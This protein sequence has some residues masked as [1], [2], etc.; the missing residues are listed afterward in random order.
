MSDAGGGNGG[1][2]GGGGS[3]CGGRVKRMKQ[4]RVLWTEVGGG[5]ALMDAAAACPVG[6]RARCVGKCPRRCSVW[7]QMWVITAFPPFRFF[8]RSH[9]R[10]VLVTGAIPSRS[11]TT[12]TTIKRQAPAALLSFPHQH[13]YFFGR[14]AGAHAGAACSHSRRPQS[15]WSTRTLCTLS[16]MWADSRTGSALDLFQ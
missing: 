7:A 1:D 15:A 13:L 8:L 9:V 2:G 10:T 14:L 11:C 12:G 4:T 6:A 5:A 16:A 3:A